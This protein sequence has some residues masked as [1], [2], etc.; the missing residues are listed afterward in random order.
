[1][2]DASAAPLMADFHTTLRAGAGF[3]EALRAARAR[4]AGDP[5]ALATALAFLALGG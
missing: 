2:N 3:G 4:S 5:V 1:V